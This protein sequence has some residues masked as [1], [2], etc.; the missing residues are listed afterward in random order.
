EASIW[1]N[2]VHTI[3]PSHNAFGKVTGVIIYSV[4]ETEQRLQE[5]EEESRKL[6]L[7]LDHADMTALALFDA[8]NA[9]LIMASPR[10]REIIAGIHQRDRDKLIGCTWQELT[11]VGQDNGQPSMWDTLLAT[12]EVQ[13]QQEL[14][15]YLAPDGPESIWDWTLTPIP[16]VNQEG[17][18]YV[19]VSAVEISDQVHIREELEQLNLLK[20]EFI[21]L[22]SHELR[23]PLTSIMGN[24]EMLERA[25]RRM[26]NGSSGAGAA[27]ASKNKRTFEQQQHTVESILHQSRRLNSL[28]D[29]ML[30]IARIHGAQFELHKQERVE[31]VALVRWAIENQ[32]AMS[33]RRITLETTEEEMS[34][35][36][37][38]TRV[39]QVLN[40]LLSNAVKYSPGSEAITVRI[41]RTEREV[42]VSVHD[43]GQGISKQQQAH[44]FD[45]Y[46]RVR[47]KEN[48]TIEG[49]G[50]GLYIAHEIITLHGGR[51]W[52]ESKR[53]EGST[54]YFS[55][56]LV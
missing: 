15:V 29:E 38:A 28:I 46:Y 4:D 33:G 10:Y 17:V 13:H 34:G 49:L 54:F 55:L 12:G 20:D 44:I 43:H 56:P 1:Q 36:W 40:N 53:G 41:E 51:M 7:I 5:I 6:R 42:S 2:F 14:H 18:R 39:E 24:A 23:T 37:D 48:T 52:L 26:L 22:A 27:E 30:D 21:S 47:T 11:M 45:R 9:E 3:V 8:Q 50:L 19:L 16:S 32:A 35:T 31:L 25:A